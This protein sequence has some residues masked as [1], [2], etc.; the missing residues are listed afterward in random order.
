MGRHTLHKILRTFNFRHL[1]N[2][3]KIFNGKNFPIYGSNLQSTSYSYNNNSIP[4]VART[5]VCGG[6]D[7]TGIE[8]DTDTLPSP[9]SMK[10]SD[11][12]S[13]YVVFELVQ[14][15]LGIKKVLLYASLQNFEIFVGIT[16]TSI[17]NL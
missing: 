6:D 10:L 1:S 2:R 15:L 8:S 9:T 3:R 5:V 16:H 12:Q 11:Y 13:L 4:V 7:D 14:N 17:L